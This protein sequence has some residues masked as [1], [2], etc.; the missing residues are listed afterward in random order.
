MAI[1][2]ISRGTHS[3]GEKLAEHL[4][5]KLGFKV[6]S[7]EVLVE[8]AKKYGISEEKLA[9]GLDRPAH[10]WE[11]LAK[12][13]QR[14]ILAVQATLAEMFP[15]AKGVYNG[16][17]G[18]FLLRGPSSV[19]KVRLIAPLEYRIKS[20]IEEFGCS[21]DE[22]VKQLNEADERRVKWVR[23]LYGADWRDPS[24]Y[25]LVV[26]LDHL[27]VASA[28]DLIAAVLERPEYRNTPEHLAA[29]KD[30]AL[31]LRVRAELTFHSSFNAEDVEVEVKDG[32][33]K[34]T[35]DAFQARRKAI[36][37]FVKKLDGVKRVGSDGPSASKALKLSGP[38]EPV[39]REIMLP[40]K[41][42]PHVHQWVSIREAIVALAASSVQL[43]DGHL[44]YPRYV[45]VF[46]AD[47]RLAGVVN[48]REVLAGLVPHLRD[49]EN[50]RKHFH[51]LIPD[52]A[53]SMGPIAWNALFS[54]AAIDKSKD[55]VKSIMLP[56]KGVVDADAPISA[57][58]SAAIHHGID[59]IPVAEGRKAVGV[60]LMTDIFDTV[61]QYIIESGKGSD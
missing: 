48:R 36:T 16:L 56:I 49:A 28:G 38:K 11:R 33:V 29:Y 17:A 46:D 27:D 47:E 18:Q 44:I 45:L 58:L 57:A 23:Q 31:G 35:G 51:G 55:P 32:A 14:Y 34:L 4:G 41:R 8:A 5:E 39:V 43:D 3:G 20:T 30:F 24:L 50:L 9:A 37:E 1:V 22:A 10:F 26:N 15:D 19:L 59:L 54:P 13:R 12:Q 61:A 40:I 60:L 21:R 52:G 6:V 53:M 25:D 42:Y 2:T 7:R